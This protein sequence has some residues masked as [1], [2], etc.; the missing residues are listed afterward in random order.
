[1]ESKYCKCGC[2]QKIIVKPFH[3]YCGIPNYIQGHNVR[4][5]PKSE[6][7]RKKLS[8]AHK[9]K[10]LSD[11]HRKKLFQGLNKYRCNHPHPMLGK[12]HTEEAKEKM[13]KAWREKRKKGYKSWNSGKTSKDDPRIPSGKNHYMYGKK[14]AEETIQKLRQKA[15]SPE[16]IK[17]SIKNLPKNLSGKNHPM[18]GKK[19]SPQTIEK[20][21]ERRMK[22]KIPRTKTKPEINF[23]RI[24]KKYGLPFKYTGDGSFWISRLNPDFCDFDNHIVVEIFGDYWHNPDKNP[25]I[26]KN[27][28]YEER[29]KEFNIN[30]WKLIVIWESEFRKGESYILNKIIDMHPKL[31]EED[32]EYVCEVIN[33]I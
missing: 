2:G 1:M 28:I 22:Q 23:I 17:I 31:S 25:H 7:T 10:K 14:H 33:T 32:L 3:K 29:E 19:H 15:L 24:C 4:G 27:A 16:R 11:Q 30:G 13:K 12:H 21:R 9:G 26:R 20:I 5:K 8:E 6:K 18:F